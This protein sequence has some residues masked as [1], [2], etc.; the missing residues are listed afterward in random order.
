MEAEVKEQLNKI[1]SGGL[2]CPADIKGLN[3]VIDLK[4][5]LTKQLNNI[6]NKI[7]SIE[8]FTDPLDKLIDPTKKGITAA[9][10]AIDAVAFIPSTVG[11]PIPVGPILQAQKGINK[12]NALLGKGDGII[13]QGI[14]GINVI[15]SK[16]QT[17]IDLLEI[18]DMLIGKCAEEMGGDLKTQESISQALLDSTNQQANQLSPVITNFNGFNLSV[19]PVEGITTSTLKRRQAIAENKQGITMLRGEPSYS[20]NDQILIDELVFYI[21]QND[22]KAE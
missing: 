9:Q 12:L 21:K 13:G 17:I 18:I 1:L 14:N 19:I 6:Y 20:S 3:K 22:L 8:S 7:E 16:L 15:K 2:S 10:T 5:K 11:T 4:N